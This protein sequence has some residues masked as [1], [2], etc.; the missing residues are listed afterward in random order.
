M[1]QAHETEGYFTRDEVEA[2]RADNSMLDVYRARK[3]T[4]DRNELG[5]VAYLETARRTGLVGPEVSL[6]EF[7]GRI[8]TDDF[9]A[10]L[11]SG[12]AGVPNSPEPVNSGESTPA[13][14]D[15]TATD[16]ETSSSSPET[17]SR[18]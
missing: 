13:F 15:T 8:R 9:N 2:L 11:G 4:T 12:R 5:L 7:L 14:S 17:S 6:E 3:T 16:L 10:V 18:D 1:S